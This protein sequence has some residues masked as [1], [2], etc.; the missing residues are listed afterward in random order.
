MS[1]DVDFESES[2]TFFN[3]RVPLDVY[4]AKFRG[5]LPKWAGGKKYKEP[6]KARGSSRGGR[7]GRKKK[8]KKSQRAKKQKKKAPKRRSRGN[9]DDL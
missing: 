7:S 1:R 3:T 8:A 4:W 5:K 2:Y 6:K 9:N